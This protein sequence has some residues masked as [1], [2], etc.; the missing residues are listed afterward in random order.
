LIDRRSFLIQALTGLLMLSPFRSRLAG[1]A[2]NLTE[3]NWTP[4]PRLIVDIPASAENGAMVPLHV[5]SHIPDTR[6]LLIFVEPNPNP[7]A[8]RF[9]FLPGCLPRVSLRIR[10]NESGP[11][12]VIARTP[13]ADYGVRRMVK[14][15]QGGCG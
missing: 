6:E 14:V 5:E 4:D 1:A 7:Q 15:M 10:I 13:S 12:R 8:A 11:V 2:G 3:R 9:E